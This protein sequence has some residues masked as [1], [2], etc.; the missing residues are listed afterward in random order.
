MTD[1][2]DLLR[3]AEACERLA[4]AMAQ[5]PSQENYDAALSLMIDHLPHEDYLTLE[6]AYG[7][8]VFPEACRARASALRW[9][10]GEGREE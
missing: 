3:R 7:W 4:E 5:N 9:Q 8:S 6:Y 10:A 2:D 1:R